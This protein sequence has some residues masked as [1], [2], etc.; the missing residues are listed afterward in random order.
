[1]SR[2]AKFVFNALVVRTT[3]GRAAGAQYARA[4]KVST[5][6]RLALSLEQQGA[7]HA[8]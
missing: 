8:V 3:L 6:Y 2:Q 5:L 4:H 1:M 7:R